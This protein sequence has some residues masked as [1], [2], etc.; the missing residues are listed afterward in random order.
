MNVHDRTGVI[1]A[2]HHVRNACCAHRADDART[3]QR[4]EEQRGG[5]HREAGAAL[6]WFFFEDRSFVPRARM[7]RLA[8][9]ASS[10]RSSFVLLLLLLPLF[11]SP[12]ASAAQISWLSPSV[13][14]SW[15]DPAN[16]DLNRV[17]AAD[18][19]HPCTCGCALGVSCGCRHRLQLRT[20]KHPV[21][22]SCAS[23][24]RST[25]FVI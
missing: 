9:R 1:G 2:R 24:P 18:G 17:P 14:G 10:L 25:L 22:R 20:A 3:R 7:A 16:W 11:A 13:G 12:L 6:S 8:S 15:H 4:H 5:G 21:Q 23:L 19:T